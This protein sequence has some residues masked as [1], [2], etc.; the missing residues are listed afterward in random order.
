[1]NDQK[2]G[3]V[4]GK[5]FRLLLVM[6]AWVVLGMGQ[7]GFAE[8]PE[9]REY[10]VKAAFLYNFVKFV[11]WPAKAFS[12]D[13]S[14]IIVAIVGDD[15]FGT[16]IETIKDKKA[17]GKSLVINS[18]AKIEDVDNC[19]I[20]FISR[21]KERHLDSIL[22]YVR[23]R[24]VLTIG[25]MEDFAQRGGIIHFVTSGNRIGFKINMD[26]AERAGLKISSRLLK[27]ADIVRDKQEKDN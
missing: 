21:S 10:Q 3:L 12:D 7:N 11:E 1:M 2:A 18:F 26:A 24:H 22:A 15:P 14:A 27:L 9:S 5:S 16:A 8:P 6:L 19:H 4:I 20:L 17:K 23:D 25:D 13:Q